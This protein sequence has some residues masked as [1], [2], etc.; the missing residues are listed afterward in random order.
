M[1]TILSWILFQLGHI[2][3]KIDCQTK[4]WRLANLYQELMFMSL[5]LDEKEK[6]WKSNLATLVRKEQKTP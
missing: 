4:G 2:V 6:I 3:W 5:R 1:K